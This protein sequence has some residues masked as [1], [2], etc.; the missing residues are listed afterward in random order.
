MYA[1]LFYFMNTELREIL[2]D[3]AEA[4]ALSLSMHGSNWVQDDLIPNDLKHEFLTNVLN[5]LEENE[6]YEYCLII[7]KYKLELE[8]KIEYEQD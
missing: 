5:L 3:A 7:H 2:L 1:A 8:K 4:I 6:K